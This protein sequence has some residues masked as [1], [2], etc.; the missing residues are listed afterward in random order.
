MEAASIALAVINA[1]AFIVLAIITWKY[2]QSTKD[3]AIEMKAT[4]DMEF[5][6]NHRPK[7][8]VRFDI[9]NS[10]MMYIIVVNEGNGAAKDIKF[11]FKPKLTA[12]EADRVEK[13]LALK[14]GIKYLQPKDRVYF[15]FDTTSRYFNNPNLPQYYEADIGYDWA[16]AGKQRITESCHLD[17]EHLKGAV[18]PFKDTSDLFNDVGKIKEEIA[19]I[20]SAIERSHK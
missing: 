7:I 17:L 15:F 4:R 2:A 1:I 3:M 13:W 5:E 9:K 18:L 14:D 19:G 10:S 6:I 8:V 11:D 16:I 12:S 20:R